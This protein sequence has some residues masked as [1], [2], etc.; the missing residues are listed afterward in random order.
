M[1]GPA[2]LVGGYGKATDVTIAAFDLADPRRPVRIGG[3]AG[4]ENASF[5]VAHP[6]LPVVYAVSETSTFD[7]GPGGGIVALRLIDR[8][9]SMIELGRAPSLGDGPCHLDVDAGGE[10]LYVANYGSGSVAA[11]A[12]HA[13]G[14]FGRR[15]GSVQH[16]GSGPT[17]RQEGPH[18][19]CVRS[20]PVAGNVYAVDLG[21]DEVVRYAVT[22]EL[23][24][25]TA[26][27]AR[28]GAGPRHLAFHPRNAVAV[29]VNELDSTL[30]T[31]DVGPDG[32]LAP[33]LTR[34]TLPDGYAQPNLAADVRFDAAGERIY[35]SNRG[36][37]SVAV[38]SC[39][40]SAGGVELIGHSP[41]G[42][43]APRCL[44]LHPVAPVMYIANQDSDEIAVLEVD[45]ATGRPGAVLDVHDM[46]APACVTIVGAAA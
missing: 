40:G 31:F 44:A 18:A 21:V 8:G 15:L 35:V 45:H 19:H 5:V 41:S 42:G 26:W 24:G 6:G 30:V 1:T 23:V 4:V 13:D 3:T 34:S 38:F 39:D 11:Y 46:I 14:R 2:L 43:Q 36:F 25:S 10:I 20:G 12:L 32:S 22:D 9:R 33:V 17:A 16:H 27:R 28:P 37:D 29:V 7:G